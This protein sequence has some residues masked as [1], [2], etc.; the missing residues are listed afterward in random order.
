MKTLIIAS[1][2]LISVFAKC[3]TQWEKVKLDGSVSISFPSKPIQNVS[4]AGKSYILQLADSTAAFI[5]AVTDMQ[6]TRGIDAATLEAAMEQ[7]ETWD[8]AKNAFMGS[9]GASAKLVKS[10]MTTVQNLKAM[11]LEID[12]KNDKGSINSLSVLIF[13][14]GTNSFNIIFN[15]RGGKADKSL[16]EQF[17]KSIEVG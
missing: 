9:M 8:E 15:N 4:N 13:V 10:E 3:Q 14:H 12:R 17:L 11:I 6:A 5:V 7:D 1:S 2:L 16:K